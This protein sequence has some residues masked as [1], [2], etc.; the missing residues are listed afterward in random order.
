MSA[1]QDDVLKGKT[2]LVVDDETD[3][4]DIVASELEFMGAK[5]FQA[6]NITVAKEI[7]SK[8]KIE[9]IVSDIR[10]P[11]GTGIDLLENVKEKDVNSP[12]VI[13]IT[14]FAD[15]TIQEAYHRGAAAMLNKPFQLDELIQVV[16]RLTG[17]CEERFQAETEPA[18]KKLSLQCNYTVDDPHFSL[19][20][21]GFA[22]NFD[23]GGYKFEVGETVD[24]ELIYDDSPLVGVAVCRWIHSPEATPGRVTLGLEFMN[25]KG[26]SLEFVIQ[27]F[28]AKKT[29]ALIPILIS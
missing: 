1:M 24:F 18:T 17:T 25:L 19:G 28:K 16:S 27:N 7:L 5:V 14:G 2:L 9:L 8:N 10:M 13:L 4:R 21:G 26:Q 3:L 12:P 20:R 23:P 6:E 22:I 15:I 11:G 29:K